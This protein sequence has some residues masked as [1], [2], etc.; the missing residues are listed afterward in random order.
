MRPYVGGWG[1][2]AEA[3]V[4]G[5]TYLGGYFCWCLKSYRDSLS[6]ILPIPNWIEAPEL[7]NPQNN[8]SHYINFAFNY[9]NYKFICTD[10]NNRSHALPGWPG[11]MP[12]AATYDYTLN[13]LSEEIDSAELTKKRIV[14]LNHHPLLNDM[15][16]CF[17]A[18]EIRIVSDCGLKNNKPI[19]VWFGGHMHP[20]G[21]PPDTTY[22]GSDTV[23]FVYTLGAAKD[24]DFGIVYVC[25]SA[26]ADIITYP[27]EFPLPVTI[28][29]KADYVYETTFY[30][31]S[32]HFDF[33]DGTDRTIIYPKDTCYH[34]YHVSNLYTDYKVA[35]TVYNL[36]G[37]IPPS[38]RKICIAKRIKVMA[39][40]YAVD[41]AYV[42][43]DEVKLT[44]SFDVPNLID[45]YKIRRG[46]TWYDINNPN[47]KWF[48]I[49]GLSPG[50]WDNYAV[51]AKVNGQL[52]PEG[53]GTY[54][55][56]QTK[57]VG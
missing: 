28:K 40:P 16:A 41:T 38:W 22:Y 20:G 19:A 21:R 45:G 39:S 42:H 37:G 34:T 14:V 31:F 43:E 5:E 53:P 29:F 52:S 18:N 57:W 32:F 13:W 48:I 50:Q 44:W 56:V 49:T 54:I 8:L 15:H 36:V 9:Q 2:Y 30:P 24:G 6:Q 27:I 7:L 47:Q 35:L 51:F 33:G 55:N 4:P 17:N 11:V 25:D 26:L 12:D 46:N 1:N 3:P 10:F 23:A